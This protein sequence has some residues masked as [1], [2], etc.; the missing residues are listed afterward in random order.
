MHSLIQVVREGI[1]LRNR[2][3]RQ[4]SEIRNPA[5]IH[6]SQ[7]DQNSQPRTRAY[8]AIAFICGLLLVAVFVL[9]PWPGS[10]T[11]TTI[12]PVSGDLS[13][14]QTRL[15]YAR[16]FNSPNLDF[17][18]SKSP[19]DYTGSQACRRCHA[20]QYES[21]SQTAHSQSFH[22]TGKSVGPADGRFDHQASSRNYESYHDGETLRHRETL[23]SREN[24]T[25]A[26]TD[27]PIKYVVGSGEHA[28]SYLYESDGF[29]FQSP[30]T[31]YSQ[32][33]RW[34]MS[35]GYDK[36]DH[37][38]FTRTVSQDCLFCHVGMIE[39]STDNAGKFRVVEQPIGCERCHGPGQSHVSFHAGKGPDAIIHPAK[40][41]RE[42]SEA[43]CQ[44]C[45]LQA[46][47]SVT[48]PAIDQW[49]FRPGQSL[50]EVR[51]DYQID[52]QDE[53]KIV[54]HV[55]Q[56]HRSACYLGS[57]TLTCITCHDPH[58]SVP[59]QNRK[60]H[61]REACLTCHTSRAC[62]VDL[63][64]RQHENDNDCAACHM[65]KLP[66]NVTHAALHHHRIGVHASD[67]RRASSPEDPSRPRLVSVL[68]DRALDEKERVRREWLALWTSD[69]RNPGDARIESQRITVSRQ[70]L[71]LIDPNKIDQESELT[72]AD[73]AN[74][75]GKLEI[76]T[77]IAMRLVA[78][79][80][81][82]SLVSNN[83]HLLL[84]TNAYDAGRL[85]IALGH[86]RRL[87]EDRVDASDLVTL[88]MCELRAGHIDKAVAALEKTLRLEPG[89]V[90][91]HEMIA[92]IFDVAQQDRAAQHRRVM[93]ALKER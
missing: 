79:S 48:A 7:L 38:S 86:Y 18:S 90:T 15:T 40:L 17:K 70:F 27:I 34:E 39:R 85:D 31:W 77:G 63:I 84:A 24:E 61:N 20:E 64:D 44:Q 93:N 53:F 55:E 87:V 2:H 6:H 29:F 47:V 69:F 88:A 72:L 91:A 82:G 75:A 12:P 59:Q 1:P 46:W 10:H 81:P 65:P 23:V 80:K 14:W 19:T 35:P 4:R 41:S 54:G 66:T 8:W 68:D 43:I 3:R 60:K 25:I 78:T 33:D 22:E 92:T 11:T 36:A 26:V 76:A 16:Q 83:S 42:K 45:H 51:S 52:G 57:D 13:D 58:H 21:Y 62:G 74:K 56:L 9:V 71:S 67:A 89:N 32:I 37:K 50:L 73:E 30:M 5:D 28:R 49:D